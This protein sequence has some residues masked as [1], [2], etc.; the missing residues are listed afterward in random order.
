[1]KQLSV[2]ESITIQAMLRV[3]ITKYWQHR[4]NS[5]WRKQIKDDVKALRTFRNNEIYLK[6]K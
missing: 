3:E 4:S 5:Y 2:S 6:E 1:M